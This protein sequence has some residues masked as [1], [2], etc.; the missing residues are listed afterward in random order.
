MDRLP[1][2]YEARV[3]MRLQFPNS[4]LAFLV[5]YVFDLQMVPSCHSE[6][7]LNWTQRIGLELDSKN[8]T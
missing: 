7:D 2:L 3:Y 8:W 1:S 4:L 6:L 5:V